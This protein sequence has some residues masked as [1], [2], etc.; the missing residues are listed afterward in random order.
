MNPHSHPSAAV[1]SSALAAPFVEGLSRHELRFQRCGACG[2]AQTLARY[3][4]AHCG[5]E[6]LAWET[7]CLAEAALLQQR[8]DVRSRSYAARPRLPDFIRVT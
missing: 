5:H 8:R 4:C 2:T 6:T 3:A 1:S 7:A